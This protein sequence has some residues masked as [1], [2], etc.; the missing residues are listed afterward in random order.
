MPASDNS[1]PDILC[2]LCSS[3][4]EG[5]ATTRE[6]AKEMICTGRPPRDTSEQMILNNYMTMQ[7][8]TD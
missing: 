7:R 6:V 8:I 2:A 1:R 3:Q 5:A 4:L